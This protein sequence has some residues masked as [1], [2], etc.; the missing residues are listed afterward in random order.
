MGEALNQ[1]RILLGLG[2]RTTRS[3]SAAAVGAAARPAIAFDDLSGMHPGGALPK[4]SCLPVQS[5]SPPQHRLEF[6][7]PK[8]EHTQVDS[9]NSADRCS[10]APFPHHRSSLVIPEFQEVFLRKPLHNNVVVNNG[11]RLVA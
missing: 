1:I 8:L 10:F 11:R 9:W 6:D 4:E 5:G 2:Y 7:Q 3:Q